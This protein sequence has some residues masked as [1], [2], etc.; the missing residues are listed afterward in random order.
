MY[1]A[2]ICNPI[3]QLYLNNV[4]E[5]GILK[6]KLNFS[7]SLSIVLA[8]PNYSKKKKNASKNSID[9]AENLMA[10]I[11]SYHKIMGYNEEFAKRG[12]SNKTGEANSNF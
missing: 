9:R 6:F 3:C 1:T 5:V 4:E 11:L 10:M 12:N 8:F 2:N 7:H